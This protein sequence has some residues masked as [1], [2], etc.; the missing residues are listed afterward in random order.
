MELGLTTPQRVLGGLALAALLLCAVV[1]FLYLSD[2]GQKADLVHRFAVLQA[3]VDSLNQSA[4]SADASDPYLSTPA[5][6]ANPP[7]LDLATLVLASA[8]QSGVTTGP[9]QVTGQGTEK[10]GNNS[11]R[12][13]TMALT[14]SGTLPQV[15]DFYDRVERGGIN[16]LT[17]DNMHL[18]PSDGRWT[19]QM[20]LVV[21]AQ[22]G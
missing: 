4:A 5:F 10:I 12:T 1:G 3:T 9:L 6:P 16:T 21:Y 8:S 11:Y 18:E 15:L 14:V 19:A 2:E 20:Q 22:A 13:M 17:F 7:N